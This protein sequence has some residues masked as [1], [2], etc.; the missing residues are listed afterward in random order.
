MEYI[1]GHTGNVETLRIKGKDVTELSGFCQ[2]VRETDLDT[3]VDNFRVL[4]KYHSAEDP[5]GNR[6]DW[7]EIDKHYR[8]VD[9]T[10]PVKKGLDELTDA[11]CDVDAA[12]SDRLAMIEDALCELDKVYMAKGGI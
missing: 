6:Y 4:K 7:Y 1:F 12:A 3:T 5:E 8:M 9:K 11:V 10:G 2:L